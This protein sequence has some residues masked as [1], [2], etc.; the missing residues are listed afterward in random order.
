MLNMLTANT[1]QRSTTE[2]YKK[3]EHHA[4]VSH[5]R[6]RRWSHPCLA[7]QPAPKTVVPRATAGG[8]LTAVRAWGDVAAS[9]AS[10][11]SHLA[12]P[13][14]V[15]ASPGPPYHCAC[16]RGRHPA[17]TSGNRHHRARG[18]PSLVRHDGSVKK[19]TLAV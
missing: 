14:L 7:W 17:R 19:W 4:H 2:N 11:R 10:G 12:G 13:R 3:E 8:G 15:L 6:R 1:I 5:D 18:A 16:L 9:R